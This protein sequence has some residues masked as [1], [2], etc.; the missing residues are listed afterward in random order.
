MQ[1]TEES[2]R[3]V[4]SILIVLLTCQRQA[5]IQ[6]H[7]PR[8]VQ[9]VAAHPEFKLVVAIDGYEP[10]LMSILDRYCISYLYGDERRGVGGSKNRVIQLLPAFQYYLFIED[11]VELRRG[12]VFG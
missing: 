10:A 8:Y 7:L 9:Y 2:G 1:P 3:D 12:D 6:L 11:D 5:L 4:A